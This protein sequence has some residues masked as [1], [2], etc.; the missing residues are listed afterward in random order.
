MSRKDGRI[1]QR[2]AKRPFRKGQKGLTEKYETSEGESQY[3]PLFITFLPHQVLALDPYHKGRS[4]LTLR[5]SGPPTTALAA[6]CDQN[7]ADSPGVQRIGRA[8]LASLRSVPLRGTNQSIRLR[9]RRSAPL[10][11]REEMEPVDSNLHK[12]PSPRKSL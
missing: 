12:N 3:G 2:L 7:C 8:I 10:S 9:M 4:N 11:D 6:S 1:R 5:F